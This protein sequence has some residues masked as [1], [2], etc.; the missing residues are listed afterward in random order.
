MDSKNLRKKNWIKYK[1]PATLSHLTLEL[2]KRR[3][4]NNNLI[5][6]KKFKLKQT[7]TMD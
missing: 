2:S 6:W 1:T 4:D 3:D 5:T 7:W